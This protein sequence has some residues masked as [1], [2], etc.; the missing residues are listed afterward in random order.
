[1]TMKCIRSYEKAFTQSK[2]TH[3]MTGGGRVWEPPA[4][5]ATFYRR[6]MP[7]VSEVRVQH[8]WPVAGVGA[9]KSHNLFRIFVDNIPTS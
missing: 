7:G 8:G 3:A 2:S 6:G 1:M 9:T 4:A 5:H